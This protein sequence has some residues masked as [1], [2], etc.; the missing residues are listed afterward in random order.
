M[1][2]FQSP[3]N[4]A[5][6]TTEQL[7]YHLKVDSDISAAAEEQEYLTDLQNAAV[8]YAETA[9]GTSLITRMITATYWSRTPGTY[10]PNYADQWHLFHLPRGPIQYVISVSDANGYIEPSNYTLEGNGNTDLLQ[11]TT[12]Y[13]SP[14]TVVYDAG[15]TTTD[16]Y[17]SPIISDIP[18]DIRHIIRTHVATLY[19]ERQS[20]RDRSFSIVP[21]SLEA[22]YQ[23]KARTTQ[24]G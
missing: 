1:K 21:H 22:F 3:P 9:M 17:G 4:Y 2:W 6:W 20:A 13:V 14:I 11:I 15:Y 19:A 18:A 8:E 5:I 16:E 7:A 12:N 24:V 10:Y 23:R